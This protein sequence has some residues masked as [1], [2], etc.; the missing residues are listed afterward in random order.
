ML[1]L[2]LIALLSLM[3]CGPA[4]AGPKVETWTDPETAAAEDPD[5]P[6]QGEYVIELGGNQ[7]G[8]QVVAMGDGKFDAVMYRG[9]LPGAGAEAGMERGRLV[10]RDS[11]V[12]SQEKKGRHFRI[13][14]GKLKA[15]DAK[16]KVVAEGERVERTSP[17]LGA[18]PPEGA[19]VLYGGKDD[20]EGWI[21]GKATE[22]G[23]L[24]V[25]AR[26]KES[27]G[28][29]RYHLEFRTPY[30][31]E[32]RG[33]GR[34]NSGVYLQNRYEVQVLDSFGLEGKDNEAGGLYKVSRPKVNMALPPLQ[35]QTYDIDFEAAKYDDEGKKIE[36]A[37]ITVTHNG[38]VIQDDVELPSQ[39]G[40]GDKE[41]P[42]S[43]RLS[44]Q[45]H[46]NPVVFRNIWF[47]PAE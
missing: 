42:E 9:G 35:W 44:L 4:L 36:N 29:G 40:G 6:V 37:R 45:Q 23:Y 5:Y 18:E 11:V 47:V 14:D 16:G 46:G 7:V 24:M 30:M 25:G 27:L 34:G 10:R 2:T 15:I 12:E 38:V 43:G 17:T 33:Q 3:L 39:T 19:V 8:V 31:P 32:A 26:S 41:S 22:E 1:R 13:E 21:K 28:S 20:A